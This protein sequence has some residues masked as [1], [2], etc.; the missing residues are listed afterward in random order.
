MMNWF[1]DW[2]DKWHDLHESHFLDIN[3]LEVILWTANYLDNFNSKKKHSLVAKKIALPVSEKYS[4]V[5]FY[6]A[7]VVEIIQNI[8]TCKGLT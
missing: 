4:Y 6:F 7:T 2:I 3:S 8:I 5:I 1:Y